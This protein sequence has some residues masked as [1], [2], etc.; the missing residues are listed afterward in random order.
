MRFGNGSQPTH[1]WSISHWLANP[2]RNQHHVNH[3]TWTFERWTEIIWL[4]LVHN[5]ILHSRL[6]LYCWFLT[7]LPQS[8]LGESLSQDWVWLLLSHICQISVAVFP[9]ALHYHLYNDT[10]R[11]VYARGLQMRS[12]TAVCANC[13]RK[14]GGRGWADV[15]A[16]A[17]IH[18]LVP[19]PPL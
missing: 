10:T 8:P 17:K 12:A 2:D 3:W 13:P 1:C 19:F 6:K 11:Q 4:Y 18:F 5:L 16:N 15:C 7:Q 14:S 9:S